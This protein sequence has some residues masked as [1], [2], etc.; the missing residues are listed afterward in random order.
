MEDALKQL[1]ALQL[2]R[3]FICHLLNLTDCV[4]QM[5]KTF[6]ITHLLVHSL[7][8]GGFSSP[9]ASKTT[10]ILYQLKNTLIIL[11]INLYGWLVKIMSSKSVYF[12]CDH[13]FWEENLLTDFLLK[14]SYKIA[15]C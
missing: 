7:A 5:S 6:E 2:T 9:K 3:T 12:F 1:K 8:H 11:N 14:K 10:G 15:L 4:K 13:I